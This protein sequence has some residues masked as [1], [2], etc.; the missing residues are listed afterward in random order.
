MAIGPVGSNG[1]VPAQLRMPTPWAKSL[2]LFGPVDVNHFL[3]PQVGRLQE[4]HV[5]AEG[6][7]ADLDEDVLLLADLAVDPLLFVERGRIVLDA[8]HHPQPG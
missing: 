5:D 1:T 8:L 3:A 2:P 6:L 7:V 4:V